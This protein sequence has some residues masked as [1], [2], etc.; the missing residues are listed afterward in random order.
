MTR[1]TVYSSRRRFFSSQ[2]SLGI[3]TI[4]KKMQGRAN[5]L[6]KNFPKYKKKKIT[7]VD[8]Q[9]YLGTYKL[10]END[11]TSASNVSLLPML[12]FFNAAMI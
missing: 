9:Q 2:S 5:F 6:Y 8:H 3:T 12:S 10:C 1:P 4:N 7:T 11:K